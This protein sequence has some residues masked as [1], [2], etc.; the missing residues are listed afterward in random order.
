MHGLNAQRPQMIKNLPP[1]TLARNPNRRLLTFS[2][3]V[4]LGLCAPMA[5]AP[6][7]AHADTAAHQEASDREGLSQIAHAEWDMDQGSPAIA[8]HRFRRTRSRRHYHY[9]GPTIFFSGR[10]YRH[11]AHSTY[12]DEPEVVVA[13]PARRGGPFMGMSLGLVGIDN[14]IGAEGGTGVGFMVGARDDN[15]AL[16]LEFLAAS[17]PVER[18]GDFVEDLQLGG[19]AANARIY[20]PVKGEI[21]PY[22]LAGVGLYSVGLADELE[23]PTFNTAVNL[24]AGV[25]FRLLRG[26]AIGGRFVHHGFYFGQPASDLGQTDDSWQAMGT[27]TV[28]F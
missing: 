20:L 14:D 22:G 26:L 23:E 10:A 7:A 24:G 3:M 11:A 19:V 17:Q 12:V 8:R 4:L 16:E 2:F 9:G 27:M 13:R 5:L 28:Y 18:R 25:D 6:S 1:G 21:E 15:F